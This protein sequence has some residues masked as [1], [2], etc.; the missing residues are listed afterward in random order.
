V[1]LF[2]WLVCL[3]VVLFAC[4]CFI[5]EV[6]GGFDSGVYIGWLL[7]R[8]GGLFGLMLCLVSL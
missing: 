8:F 3:S 1:G 6:C 2:T 5:L 4:S 7:L